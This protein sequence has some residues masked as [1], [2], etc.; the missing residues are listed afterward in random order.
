MKISEIITCAEKLKD[1]ESDINEIIEILRDV[2][3]KGKQV[4]ICG[5]GG[6]ASTATHFAADLFKMSDIKAVSLVD[7]IPLVSAITNDD[8]WSEVYIKQLEKWFNSGDILIAISVHGG[9]GEDQA[10]PWSQN[11]IRAI[12][13]A[14]SRK[15]KVIGFAGF[16]GGAMR[17]MCDNCIVIPAESTP[18]VE[19]FHSIL[20]HMISFELL[21]TKR[22]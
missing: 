21:E 7:N 6:S 9:S 2:K 15:G 5:N 18:I 11:L 10:G 20:H 19:S 16:D 4:F 1:Q 22:E 3:E 8:G 14:Q 13:F 17:H 12:A